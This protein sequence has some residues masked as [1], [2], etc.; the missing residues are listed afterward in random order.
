MMADGIKV[1][2]ARLDNLAR[3]I[4]RR[5]VGVTF[6]EKAAAESA[7]IVQAEARR[8][9][10]TGSRSGRLYPR[11]QGKKWH[12]ASAPTEPLKSDTGHLAA[13]IFA[14]LGKGWAEVGTAVKYGR[15]WEEQ[16]PASRRRPWLAPSFLKHKD[17]IL[18]KMA[19]A[20]RKAMGK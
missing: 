9:L 17:R 4:Q 11:Q 7:T 20:T 15:Y 12:Q 5:R 18:R 19:A 8:T 2:V 16:A 1:K 13:H 3:T 10:H 6:I 14:R